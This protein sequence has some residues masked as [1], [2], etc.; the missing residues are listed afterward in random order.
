MKVDNMIARYNLYTTPYDS[1]DENTRAEIEQ[2][3]SLI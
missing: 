3:L 1:L 2:F